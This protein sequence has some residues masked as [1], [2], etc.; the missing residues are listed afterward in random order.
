MSLP[1]AEAGLLLTLNVR[2]EVMGSSLGSGS[3][4]FPRAPQLPNTN[5]LKFDRILKITIYLG[6][7]C[8]ENEKELSQEG[9]R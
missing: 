8:F 6:C 7:S 1:V 2:R 3:T 9:L 4:P 5:S